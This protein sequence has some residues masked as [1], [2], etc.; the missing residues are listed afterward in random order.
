[1][2]SPIRHFLDISNHSQTELRAI[3]DWAKTVKSARKAGGVAS[4]PLAGKTVAMIFEQPSLRTRVSFEVGIRDLGGTPM[5]LTAAEIEMGKRESIA[6]TARVFS[7]YV[8]AIMIRLLNH[9]RLLELA[10]HASIP[11]I[12]GL[13]K[14]SHP[15]QVMADVM[16]FEEHRG[17]IA[18]R[19]VA[20]TGDSNNV[21]ASWIHASA[22]L[23]FSLDIAT[24]EELAPSSALMDWAKREG[25]RVR[26]TASPERAVEGA[27]CVV[28]DTW[29]SMGDGDKERRNNLLKRYQVNTELLSEAKPDAVFMHCLPA[30]RGKEVTDEVMDGPNSVVFDEA[31]NRLHAQKGILA[32]CFGGVAT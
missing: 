29:V 18:G 21:L 27:D 17:P 1:V 16:T 19:K 25:A 20:W 13:T 32:W 30:Y 22:R 26:H 2:T 12:N 15:C 14:T 10:K 28:T 7:R 5:M 8:D 31:E 9:D 6:D 4:K 23:D 3:L 11:V 24:P